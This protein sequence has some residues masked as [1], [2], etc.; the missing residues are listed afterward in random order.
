MAEAPPRANWWKAGLASVVAIEL[1]GGLSGWLSNSGFGNAWFDS[2][3]KPFFMP[4]G[5]A[6][7][8]VWPMLYA[9][10][11]IALALVLAERPSDRRT[12]GLVLFFAQLALNFLWSPVFFA[13]H[14]I[15]LAKWLIFIMAVLAAA[16]AGQFLRIRRSAGLL[17]VP[18]LAWLVFAASLNATIDALNPGAGSSLLG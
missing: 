10:M 6:F 17:L 15:R 8:I 4:P 5:W 7:G 3:Q 1:A 2:L 9:L 12:L 18:Y 14:D 16:S 11:G 13:G